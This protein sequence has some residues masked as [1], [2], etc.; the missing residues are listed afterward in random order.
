MLIMVASFSASASVAD[1]VDE[2]PTGRGAGRVFSRLFLPAN[3]TE[4][5]LFRDL[6]G[7]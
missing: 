1:R 7:F 4:L 2:L 3:H 6:D 5:T